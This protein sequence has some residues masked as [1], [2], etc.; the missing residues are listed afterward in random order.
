MS[1]IERWDVVQINPESD[2]NPLFGGFIAIVYSVHTWGIVALIY[3]FQV[4]EKTVA[5]IH[6]IR[7]KHNQ[8][9][10]VGP[11]TFL[12]VDFTAEEKFLESEE[13]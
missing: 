12:P 2:V 10:K 8:Y 13:K 4:K 5:G 1:L 3:T 6:T 11:A 9:V 7:L